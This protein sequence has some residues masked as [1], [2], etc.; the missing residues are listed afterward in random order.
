MVLSLIRP[1]LIHHIPPPRD[2]GVME[3]ELA[4]KACANSKK[5]LCAEGPVVL[6]ATEI[7]ISI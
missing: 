1:L 7:L 6:G 3:V 5:A 4:A 2:L